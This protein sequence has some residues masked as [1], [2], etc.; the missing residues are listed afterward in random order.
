V[1]TWPT[2]FQCV[3]IHACNVAVFSAAFA[4]LFGNN[5]ATEALFGFDLG[6]LTGIPVYAVFVFRR[7][8]RRRVVIELADQSRS[9]TASNPSGGDA[10]G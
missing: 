8:R 3:V 2:P 9:T 10:D 1:R 7:V 6:L 5:P 4:P